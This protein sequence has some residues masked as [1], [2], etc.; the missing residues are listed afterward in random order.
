MA[1]IKSIHIHQLLRLRDIRVDFAEAGV[2]AIMG[3][4]GT[5]KTTLLQAMACVYR[6]DTKITL[7]QEQ[8]RY[9]DFF[10]DYDGNDWS[11]SQFDV[12]FTA[13][14][15]NKFYKKGVEGWRPMTQHKKARYTK[16]ISILECVPDQEKERSPS[17]DKYAKPDFGISNAKQQTLIEKIT[18]ALRRSYIT[19][20]FAEK[21]AGLKQFMHVSVNDKTLGQIDYPS[22]YMGAG[23]QKIIH[24]IKE[25]LRA[26]NK[27]L[28]LIEELEISLHDSAIKALINFLLEQA[29]QRK[30]QIV[31][32]TH[33]LRIQEFKATAEMNIVSLFVDPATD[34]VSVR[35]KFDPQF[36][37]HL[38][39]DYEQRRQIK[40]WVEDGLAAKIVGSSPSGG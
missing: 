27:A 33:W 35:N 30:L 40:V 29:Q 14:N 21:Q 1:A 7:D 19:A 26:P 24:I 2:T 37:H 12:S 3:A 20:C 18:G 10:K 28:I 15:E 34:I 11:N 38:N 32:T 5:G 39:D 31:F 17:I 4:N 16:Y 9:T 23:E 22:H 8:H 6:N 36:I 13:S 25:V